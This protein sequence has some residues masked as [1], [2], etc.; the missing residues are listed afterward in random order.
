MQKMVSGLVLLTAMVCATPVRGQH[1]G[2]W[3]SYNRT[4]SGH[5]FAPL[6]EINSGNVA[7]LKKICSVDLPEGKA[8][9][10]GLIAVDGTIYAT[11]DTGTFAID[12]ESCAFKWRHDRPYAPASFLGSNRGVAYQNGR[13][14]RGAGDA[15]VFAIDAATGTTVWDVAIG[16]PKRGESVPMAPIAWNDMVFIGNAGG[17]NFGVTGRVYALSASDGHTIWEFHTVPDTP[18]VM[19]TWEKASP[20]NPPTGGGVWTTF[21][22]D[23]AKGILYVSAGNPAPDFAKQLH[24]GKN[25]YT[26]SIIA[27]DARTGKMLGYHQPVKDD[28]HDWDVSAAPALVSTRGNQ[29]LALVAAKDGMLHAVALNAIDMSHGANAEREGLLYSVPTTTRWNT[30]QTL[31]D[32]RDTRFCPGS[33]GGSEW[34]GAAYDPSLNLAIVPA[35]D[36]CTSVRLL[37]LDRLKGKPGSAWTGEIEGGFGKQDLKEKWKG[38]VT[39]FDA[40]TGKQAW[41][42]RMPTPMLAGVTPTAGGVTFAGDLNGTVYALHS[43]T[44]RR[45]WRG[46][47]GQPIGGGIIAYVAGGKQ[48]IG[49]AAG[50]KSPIWPVNTTTARVVVFG[51][52]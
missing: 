27:L 3:P 30:E 5:R 20:D 13:L 17:D 34:N 11:T 40:D 26:N 44:G 41:Q 37:P 28:F 23:T 42:V 35:V 36:W 51:L 48:R 38:W 39:A 1:F 19:A 9:Q 50:M 10:T 25:L 46:D 18:E 31:S 24:P 49:V 22:M 15:H 4:L 8:F 16:D 45:L 33:Q 6:G 32:R 52:P 29:S 7:K 2:D 12:G 47:A 21:S 14:F 43:R